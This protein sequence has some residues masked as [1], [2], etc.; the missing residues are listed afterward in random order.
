[1]GFN[2]SRMNLRCRRR[3]CVEGLE[4]RKLLAATLLLVAP[5]SVR[6]S[7]DFI[8]AAEVRNLVPGGVEGEGS[9]TPLAARLAEVVIQFQGDVS[10]STITETS[11]V[12][13]FVYTVGWDNSNR[14]LALEWDPQTGQGREILL[15]D[16]S[17][18]A[19]G[20]D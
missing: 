9:S 6:P 19:G 2:R 10:I 5:E 20:V 7:I 12:N 18:L 8:I 13:G 17:T 16:L 1:M 3:L 15:N 11:F 14:G 4:S